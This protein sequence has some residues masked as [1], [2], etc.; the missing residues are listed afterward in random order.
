MKIS[1]SLQ[2]M[3]IVTVSL[4]VF[5]TLSAVAQ[6]KTGLSDAEVASVAVVAN[7][8]DIDFAQIAKDKSKSV[9][10]GKIAVVVNSN[11]LS[12]FATILA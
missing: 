12:F 11:S 10:S 8:I 9:L 4:L 2:G 5:F 1:K 3:S 7:R 6:D